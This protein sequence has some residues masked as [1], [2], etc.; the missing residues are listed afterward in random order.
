MVAPFLL[1]ALLAFF[2]ATAS[3]STPTIHKVPIGG[4]NQTCRY[5][6]G[7]A[8][9]PSQRQWARLNSTV[10]GRL[11]AT[12]PVAHVCHLQGQFAAYDQE[13]CSTLGT[14]FQDSGPATLCPIPGEVLN[15]YWQNETCSPFTAPGVSCE[16]GNRAAYSINVTGPAD[17]QA[18]LAFAT[19]NNIRLVIRNTGI[20]Y[21][22][23]STG[24]GALA[25]WTYNLKA[26]E[27]IPGYETP[28]YTGPTVKLGAGVTA[29]EAYEAV[30]GSGYRIIAPECGLTGVVGGYAQGGGQSQLITAYGMAADQVLE[31]EL[32]TPRGEYLLA[33]PEHNSDL[34]WALAGGGGGTNGVVLGA[35]FKAYPE[36]PVAGGEMVVQSANT[37]ALFEA[38]GIWFHQ[39][40]SYVESSRNNIQFF[41]TNDTLTVL[42]FVMPDQ[43]ASSIDELL[44]P[45]LPE[46]GRLGLNYTF[47]TTDYPTYLD[48]FIASYGP[49][50][51][52][53]L[54]PSFPIISSR[55]I[56]RATVLDPAANRRLVDLYRNITDGGTW[57][58]GCSFL[59][60][61]DSPGSARPPHPPNSVHPVWRSAVAYCNPQ[62]HG[63]YGWKE[64]AA[65]TALRRTLVDDIFPALEAATPGG[66]VQNEIDP[67][68]RGDWK[69]T[70]YGANYDRLLS[71]KHAYDPSFNMYGLF[72]VGS[73]E[74]RM[75]KAGRLCRA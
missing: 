42:N 31:W 51:Y 70:F 49:L 14:A 17:V 44:G 27:I 40:P 15:P 29:G 50:P 37:T 53:D 55:V 28:L 45:F 75:D 7:D 12:V 2:A 33:T 35:T 61:D 52:G 48:S 36:G 43:N 10:G 23:K 34:Y 59:N 73:D 41:V 62:T 8:G 19:A 46:L 66:A 5:I 74:F 25:L 58:V 57:W 1:P 72:A 30:Q 13:S 18:G 69:E 64:P 3:T 26:I 71:I 65:V 9:W 20:D 38:I 11:I 24:Q 54:C 47:T 16:L 56:P 21:L 22:G 6:P 39:G 4:G 32:V 67:T 60:V 63:P 68:Y